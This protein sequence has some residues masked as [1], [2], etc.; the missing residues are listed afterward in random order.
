VALVEWP[1]RLGFDPLLEGEPNYG[2]EVLADNITDEPRDHV[3]RSQ[4]I[5]TALH[6]FECRHVEEVPVEVAT[7]YSIELVNQQVMLRLSKLV[8]RH[9]LKGFFHKLR[10]TCAAVA[11]RR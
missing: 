1:H 6:S 7:P 3:H 5:P 8:K 4:F 10:D 2:H 9:A 11:A